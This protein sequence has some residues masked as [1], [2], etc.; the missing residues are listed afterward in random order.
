L[1][2]TAKMLNVVFID[3][4]IDP[5]TKKVLDIGG[6]R[7]DGVSYHGTSMSEFCRFMRGAEYVCGHNIVEHDLKYVGRAVR[8]AGIRMEDAIDTLYLSPLLFPKRPYHKLVKDDKL[9]TDELNNPLNDSIKAMDLFND[10]INA[11]GKLDARLKEIFCSLLGK[12]RGFS[13][14][15][16]ACGFPEGRGDSFLSRIRRSVLQSG[17]DSRIGSMIMDYFG[18]YI[19]EHASVEKF[20]SNQPVALSYAL[21]VIS[22]YIPNDTQSLTPAWVLKNHPEVETILQKLRNTPCI[23]GCP[24]CNKS[25]DIHEGLK[26]YFGFNSF[27]T[28]GGANLQEQAV[29]AAVEG[30]SLL[31]VFPTG[32]G[33]S[34]T[35]QLPALMAGTNVRGLTVVISP[36]QSLMKDQVDNLEK[37]GIT[38]A[39][40]INGLLDPIERA[41]AFE[42]V[43]DGSASILYSAPESLRSKS[44][45]RLMLE[46]T[47][48]RFVIDE[49]H[50]FS[51]WGQDFRVDYLYIGDFIKSI[52]EKKNLA[53]SIP[54]SCF[55]ATAKLKVIE[56]ISKYFKDKLSLDL[57][58]FTT[59]ASRTN[60]L[61]RVVKK[62]NDEEKYNAIRDL[63]EE[64]D[65]PT[66]IYVS[67]TRRAEELAEKLRSD[68]FKA[69][70]FHGKMDSDLKQKNQDAFISGEV[71]IM[72]ATSAFGMGV[73]KKDVGLVIHHDISDSLENYVQEAG[74]AGRDE[75]IS[76]ECYV[77]FNDEDLSKHFIL[78]NQTKISVKEIQQIWRAVK[79]LTRSRVKVSDSALEIARKA[80]WDDSIG[81]IE[82]RVTAAIAALEDAGYLKREQ[83]SPV[84]Y[85]TSI[86]AASAQDA[87]DKITAS[88][89][90]DAKDK[91]NATRIIKSLISSRS[92]ADAVGEEG[93]S[94]VDW[95]SDTLGIAKADVIKSI[96]LLRE[97]GI[98]ADEK[99][100]TIFINKKETLN[101][102]KQM[103]AAFNSVEDFLLQ[104]L[105][106]QQKV[107]NLKNLMQEAEE[108]GRKS[109]DVKRIKVLLNVWS[110]PVLAGVSQSR[111][112][113]AASRQGGDQ[114]KD[115]ALSGYLPFHRG[116]PLCQE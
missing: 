65:C 60:L 45:E 79:E 38:D 1:D 110:M 64:K 33:K 41:K 32:G 88:G 58:L 108:E 49:A 78:L 83:N 112:V 72:V 16:K 21:S 77:L 56:D 5:K 98:L 113:V 114:G 104:R 26:R 27:R 30:K 99:D 17:G 66:I 81:E 13:G 52:Q 102:S 94:R 63:V 96:N 89:R 40:T 103:V 71:R 10:E 100:L 11:F 53:E 76:A 97:E 57:K 44:K 95:I 12:E 25:Y 46:R 7:S 24:Y 19:C 50:C 61:Y 4:E 109:V 85:A 29:R 90:F 23:Q 55:T 39:V 8:D 35:F 48:S 75:R 80:G 62:E 67:R 34:I 47:I 82:T 6:V 42:R 28:Y 2:D 31:A 36:L 51:S 54:V 115:V 15:F 93:E 20:V 43:A 69:L 87:I 37:H 73:D 86:H 91:V 106:E 3:T 70:A 68:G 9:Q 18:G 84:V 101:R 59:T 105:D 107:L 74:R 14:F 92:K 111:E 22:T 116:I